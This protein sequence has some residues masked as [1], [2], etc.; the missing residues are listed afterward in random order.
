MLERSIRG[1]KEEFEMW[2]DEDLTKCW[3][4]RFRDVTLLRMSFTANDSIPHAE[5]EIL[6]TRSRLV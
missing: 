1:R 5:M 4:L 6:S 3:L 2:G